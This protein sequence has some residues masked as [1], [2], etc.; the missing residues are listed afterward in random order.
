MERED[1]GPESRM[2]ADA[3]DV[4]YP[5]IFFSVFPEEIVT[6]FYMPPNMTLKQ[7]ANIFKYFLSFIVCLISCEIFFQDVVQ[8]VKRLRT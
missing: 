4:N 1:D 7:L 8:K 3:N 5:N 6:R 2:Q